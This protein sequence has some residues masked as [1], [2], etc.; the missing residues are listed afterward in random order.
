MCMFVSELHTIITAMI[1]IYFKEDY[2]TL[3]RKYNP[4]CKSE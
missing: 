2:A 3:L 1:F 4:V